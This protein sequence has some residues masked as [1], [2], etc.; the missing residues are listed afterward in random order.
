M[1]LE[2]NLLLLLPK[3]AKEKIKKFYQEGGKETIE[4]YTKTIEREYNITFRNI[5]WDEKRGLTTVSATAGTGIDLDGNDTRFVPHNIYDLKS[6]FAQPSV[7][8]ILEY[9]SLLER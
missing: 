5:L 8:V 9:L 1:N 3:K 4:A 6:E 2:D 7:K